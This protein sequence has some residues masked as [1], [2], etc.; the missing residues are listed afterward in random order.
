MIR[1]R[2]RIVLSGMMA[3]VPGQGG[4]TWA[5]LQYVLGLR[6]LG[7]D[8]LFV[9]PVEGGWASRPEVVRYFQGLVDRFGLEG[10]AALVRPGSR[11]TLGLS[12][13]ELRNWTRGADLLLNFSGLLREPELLEPIRHRVYVDLDPAFTQLWSEVEGI[14]MGFEGHHR[15][16]SVGL[17]LGHPGCPIPDCGR[18]W[19]PTLPP[20]VL[21]EWPRDGAP[22]RHPFS[23]VANWRGYGSVVHQ[24]VFHGQKA[25]ALRELMDLPRRTSEPLLLALA[26]HEGDARDRDALEAHGWR[27]VDPAEVAATPDAYRAFVA[28]SRG[29]FGVA[30]TGYVVSRSGWF[31]DRSAC[32]LAS[33]RPV[34]AQDTGFSSHLPVGEG[35]LSFRSVEDA[36]AALEELGT[37][38]PRHSRAARE[39][40]EAHLD[41]DRVL[42]R[43]LDAV[44]ASPEQGGPEGGV[45]RVTDRELRE[46]LEGIFP[47]GPTPENGGGDAAGGGRVRILER[48]MS[49]YRTSF[50]LEELDLSLP[51]GTA[52][53]VLFK[54][55]APDSLLDEARRA[56]PGFLANP[57]REG[58]VYRTL[59]APRGLGPPVH[60]VVDDPAVGR[61]WLFLG[62]APGVELY[63]VGDLETW[64]EV[65]RWLA[66]FH[67]RFHADEVA[68]SLAETGVLIHHDAVLFRRW[69]ERARSFADTE[70]R[71]GAATSQ[72]LLDRVERI[73]PEV[74]RVLLSQP[75]TL[76]HGEFYPSNVLVRVGTRG[77]DVVPVDWEMAGWGPGL[78]DLAALVAG[79]W[80]EAERSWLSLA[81]LEGLEEAGGTEPPA[82]DAF[83]EAVAC[84]RLQ[85]A[86]QWMG[87]A[88]DWDPPPEHLQDWRREAE[89]L[90]DRLG[91]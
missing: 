78:L 37:R 46:A 4:A 70:G 15:F 29:E 87:W 16:A 80:S 61:H 63:Q 55:L 59:L 81:Y 21:P 41:S 13:G 52:L 38:Y 39:L 3:G 43:L 58:E 23:T 32:Y 25:H 19:I 77:V 26:I 62:R 60:G 11:E 69:L 84:A 6:R 74:S 82:S 30:K 75:P 71:A 64:A 28:G 1:S 17:S 18:R 10:R 42:S 51:D 7:H 67:G 91:G 5:V 57:S 83:L 8:V 56:K 76:L 45:G 9:E 54:D 12:H 22:A 33:G 40:A 72:A 68:R 90:L 44:Q 86:V 35:L 79:G 50:S 2:V 36:A 66:R 14:D 49:P 73:H 34:L 24:G 47:P 89:A 31:S 85:L 20:V 27:L 48:R 65:A 53:D 88:R